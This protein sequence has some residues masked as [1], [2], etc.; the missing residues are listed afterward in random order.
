MPLA[1][2]E[3]KLADAEGP[4]EA[5][6]R[7]WATALAI[8]WL[9]IEANELVDEWFLLE[10]KARK[11]RRSSKAKLPDGESWLEAAAESLSGRG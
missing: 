9:K 3:K 2:L 10:K 1:E 5:C 8:L 6:R 7:A 11:W 4:P